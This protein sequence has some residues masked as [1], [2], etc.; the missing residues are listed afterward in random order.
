MGGPSAEDKHVA[1]SVK[2][3]K[4]FYRKEGDGQTKDYE[5][6][7]AKN[8]YKKLIYQ[9]HH[10]IPEDAIYNKAVDKIKNDDKRRLVKVSM[11]RSKWNIND[12]DN[13]IGLPD[14]YSFLIY[15][16]RKRKSAS[17]TSVDASHVK[18]NQ[19]GGYILR[20]IKRLNQRSSNT[21]DFIDLPS[22]FGQTSAADASPERYP[23]HLP[24]S[25][26]HTK[27]NYAVADDI[28]SDVINTIEETAEEH[29]LDFVDVASEFETI[30]SDRKT[31]LLD[32]AATA[33]YELWQKRYEGVAESTWRTPFTMAEPSSPLKKPKKRKASSSSPAKKRKTK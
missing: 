10:I 3:R 23:V 25:W 32:R 27:Y 31:Y 2:P 13:L 19:D 1:A 24:V 8:G 15:F 28:Q 26:G 16:D 17:D 18:G 30:A 4:G 21:K 6:T 11:L 20:K 5:K 9:I 33:T 12:P 7:W 14:L 22:L 29:E